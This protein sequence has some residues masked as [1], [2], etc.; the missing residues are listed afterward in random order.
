V[1]INFDKRL[2]RVIGLVGVVAAVAV[3]LMVG[4]VGVAQNARVIVIDDRGLEIVIDQPVGR[5]VVAGTPLYSE[6]LVD[7]GVDDLIVGVAESAD[8]PEEVSDLP[9]IGTSFQPNIEEVIALEPDVVFGALFDARDQL[10]AAGIVVVTP[11]GFITSVPDI[12]KVIRD[13]GAIV[14][15]SVRAE[16]LIGEISSEI[17]ELESHVAQEERLTAAFLFAFSATDPPFTTPKGS[18]EGELISRAGGINIFADASPDAPVSF[19]TIIERNPDVIF[20]DPSQI[21]NITGNPLLQEID[22]VVNNRVY[23]VSASALTSTRVVDALRVMAA[24]LHP[25]SF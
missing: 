2:I 10:E 9:S 22:A 12:F 11:V 13:V 25:E 5:I 20:T 16:L 17:V 21:E 15:E 23:G 24:H 14:N 1:N 7:L 6:I 18:V 4:A 3:G 19:E 8:N